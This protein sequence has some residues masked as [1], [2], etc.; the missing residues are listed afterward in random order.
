MLSQVFNGANLDT[1]IRKL[2]D[3]LSILY[4]YTITHVSKDARCLVEGQVRPSQGQW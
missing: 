4:M 1:E 3:F 2:E